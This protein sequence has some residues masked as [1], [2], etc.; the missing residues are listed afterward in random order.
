MPKLRWTIDRS[1]KKASI[2]EVQRLTKRM[3]QASLTTYIASPSPVLSK[4]VARVI[5]PVEDIAMKEWQ[6][7][8]AIG[9]ALLEA[10]AL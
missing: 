3:I 5:W 6:I 10:S 8:S 2:A 9:E 4:Y 7:A 1:I